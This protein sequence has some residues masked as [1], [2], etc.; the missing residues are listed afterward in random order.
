VVRYDLKEV[1][2]HTMLPCKH[3]LSIKPE[4]GPGAAPRNTHRRQS[5]VAATEPVLHRAV[6]DAQDVQVR[7]LFIYEQLAQPMTPEAV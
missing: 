2:R 3:Q 6:E 1:A 5:D 7:D 4:R